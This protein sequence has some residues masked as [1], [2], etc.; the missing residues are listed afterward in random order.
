MSKSKYDTHVEPRYNDIKRWCGL[1][2]S[3]KDIAIN[4]GI[5]KGTFCDYKKRYPELNER[6]KK[7]RKKPVDEIKAAML[8]RATGFL[9]DETKVITQRIKLPE[10][11]IYFLKGQGISENDIKKIEE[12]ELVKTEIYQKM[13]LPDVAAGLVLLKHWDKENGWTTDPQSLELKKKELKFKEKQSENN[14]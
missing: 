13:A 5:N 4:L 1:G 8:R 6:L 9:Y 7:Y 10:H 14:W 3:D 11:V 2:M 12:S